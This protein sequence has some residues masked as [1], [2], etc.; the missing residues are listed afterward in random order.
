MNQISTT[1]IRGIKQTGIYQQDKKAS[2][3]FAHKT[4]SN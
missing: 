1:V 4:S 3:F 2:E